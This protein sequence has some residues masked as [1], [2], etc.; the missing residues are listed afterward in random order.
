MEDGSIREL[1]PEDTIWYLIY[2]LNPPQSDRMKAI[3]CTRFRLP[4]D[5]FLSFAD[6]LSQHQIFSRWKCSDATGIAPSNFELLLLGSLR[7]VGRSWTFD[8]ISE[9]NSISCEDN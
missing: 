7:Y 9:T 6:E 5:E 8:D 4:Y 1:K 3:F 2:V